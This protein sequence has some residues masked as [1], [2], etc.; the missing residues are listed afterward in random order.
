MVPNLRSILLSSGPILRG[1]GFVVFATAELRLFVPE[2][3]VCTGYFLSAV[4]VGVSLCGAR[5]LICG[6]GRGLS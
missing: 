3:G 5:S 1:G 4:S 2:E 6:N